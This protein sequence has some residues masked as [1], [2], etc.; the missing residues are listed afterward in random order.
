MSDSGTDSPP[1]VEREVERLV[2]VG[3]SPLAETVAQLAVASGRRVTCATSDGP[4]ERR[5]PWVEGVD[6]V[7]IDDPEAL[8][9]Q[10]RGAAA[11]VWVESGSTAGGASGVD[12]GEHL[13]EE[14]RDAGVGR[15]VRVSLGDETTDFALEG[16]QDDGLE[17]VDLRPGQLGRSVEVESGG[18]GDGEGEVR[19]EAERVGM[20]ALRAALEEGRVGEYGPSDV[21]ELGDAVMIQG[22]DSGGGAR[23]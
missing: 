18:E 19:M 8:D 9:E 22:Q 23:G 13:V 1:R 10:L 5:E 17:V 2:V 4:P 7:D 16:E 20:A 21:A 6:W 15:I 14:V 11:V 3:A 12:T